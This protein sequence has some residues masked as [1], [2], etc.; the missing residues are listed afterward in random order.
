LCAVDEQVRQYWI[1]R[2]L[3]YSSEHGE[4]VDRRFFMTF[5]TID[6]GLRAGNDSP[7]QLHEWMRAIEFAEDQINSYGGSIPAENRRDVVTF[8]RL[9]FCGLQSEIMRRLGRTEDSVK[10]LQSGTEL[11][12]SIQNNTLKVILFGLAKLCASSD[13]TGTKPI[14]MMH[15]FVDAITSANKKN[16]TRLPGLASERARQTALDLPQSP[17]AALQQPQQQKFG[18]AISAV[19]ATPAAFYVDPVSPRFYEMDSTSSSEYSPVAT[20]SPTS[21]S[22]QAYFAD[23]DQVQ[24]GA[25]DTFM[26]EENAGV[27]HHYQ[28]PDS[29]SSASEV[30]PM[31][32]SDTFAF[33]M[34]YPVATPNG[35]CWMLGR[36]PSL[37]FV[38]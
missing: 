19:A 3:Q 38:S 1:S 27:I 25:G 36:S 18:V 10:L 16:G 23:E 6:T 37:S 13:R 33:N 4:L 2:L 11:Y 9:W 5:S 29:S 21:Y 7:A 26:V 30:E 28:S 12:N 24:Q 34:I 14:L 31:D 32:S 17:N 22:P 20:P 35:V 15:S 8:Y